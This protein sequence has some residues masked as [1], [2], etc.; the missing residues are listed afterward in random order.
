M[1]RKPLLLFRLDGLL[2]FRLAQRKLSAL[3]LFQE[4][5]LAPLL[6]G[7]ILPEKRAA[8]EG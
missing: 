1:R 8:V 6:P 2:L 5:P 7:E 4:P 3:L